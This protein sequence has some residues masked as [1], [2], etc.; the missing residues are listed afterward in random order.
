MEHKVIREALTIALYT[1]VESKG[2]NAVKGR[3]ITIQNDLV[4]S[5]GPDHI[6]NQTIRARYRFFHDI[7][8]DEIPAEEK[9]NIRDAVSEILEGGNVFFLLVAML[10]IDLSYFAAYF[11]RGDKGVK[12]NFV[13]VKRARGSC[14]ETRQRE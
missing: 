8:L 14:R 2:R 1:L 3:Q 11:T 10:V 12:R 13:L 5:N 4:P 9:S 6:V 7:V